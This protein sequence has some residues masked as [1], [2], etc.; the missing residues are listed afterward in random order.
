MNFSMLFSILMQL[1]P[2]VFKAVETVSA[3]KGKPVQD[4]VIDVINHLT[5]GQPN[6]PALDFSPPTV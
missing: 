1:L 5:P 6:A 2:T 4:V 3:D